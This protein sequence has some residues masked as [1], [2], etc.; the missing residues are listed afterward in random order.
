MKR[1]FFFLF[2]IFN[3]F[4]LILVSA[5]QLLGCSDV[6]KLKHPAAE[7]SLAFHMI[8]CVERIYQDT[9]LWKWQDLKQKINRFLHR[10]QICPFAL[11]SWDLSS[12][13][14]CQDA[15]NDQMDL[16]HSTEIPPDH[17]S[18]DMSPNI[19]PLISRWELDKF[20]NRWN[21]SF[22][23]SSDNFV[24]AIFKLVNFP[25]RY[26]LSKIRGTVL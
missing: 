7:S 1:S 19:G 26:E 23:T 18:L 16:V 5:Q 11:W 15:E 24:S 12:E 8:L 20:K 6:K 21:K 2:F 25:T 10:F 9:L 17:L 13:L 4:F 3:F 22:K 14:S